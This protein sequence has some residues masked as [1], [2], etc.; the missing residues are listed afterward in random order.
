MSDMAAVRETHHVA[1][2]T[3]KGFEVK[4][5]DLIRITDLDGSQ[6]VDFWAFCK[7]DHLEFLSCEHTKPSIEKLFPHVGD[8]AYTNRRRPLGER[9]HLELPSAVH[10][11]PD[12]HRHRERVMRLYPIAL[13]AIL[14]VTVA[15]A[16]VA[17]AAQ[18]LGWEDLAPPF[19]GSGDPLYRLSDDIQADFYDL[20]WARGLLAKMETLSKSDSA[21][22]AAGANAD[23][24]KTELE[25]TEAEARANLE[26]AGVDIAALIAEAEAYDA[27]LV[28]HNATLVDALDG[29]DVEIPGFALPLEYSG[30][31]IS[32][33]LL[34]PYV[35][36]CIHVPPPPPNQIVYVRFAEGFE[37]KGLF[38]PV[39]VAGRISAGRSSQSLSY[40]DGSADIAVGYS[41]DATAIEVYDN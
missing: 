9:T 26:A 32:E 19:D 10:S 12:R 27:Q 22:R 16:G 15:F 21:V 4:T 1:A 35:G 2:R 33:F 18:R 40:V 38:T 37:S 34:V 14:A 41:L 3:G 24:V 5:D 6:P 23:Y 29:R 25:A 20:M 17:G 31:E 28:V 8:S 11:P 30:T 36:A 13:S 7:E 39:L